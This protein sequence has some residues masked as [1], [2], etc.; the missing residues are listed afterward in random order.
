MSEYAEGSSS[1]VSRIFFYEPS[2]DLASLLLIA[3]AR[4]DNLVVN[5][6][7]TRHHFQ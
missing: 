5:L 6:T 2:W 4:R 1:V 3:D 7:S